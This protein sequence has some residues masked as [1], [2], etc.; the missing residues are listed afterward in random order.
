[1]ERGRVV[2]RIS[3]IIFNSCRS[4]E[5]AEEIVSFLEN[6]AGMKFGESA[7]SSL[8][9]SARKIMDEDGIL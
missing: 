2:A 9:E 7:E 8:L 1:M 3:E 5:A 6:E 4:H